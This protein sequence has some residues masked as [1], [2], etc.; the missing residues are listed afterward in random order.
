MTGTSNSADSEGEIR[1]NLNAMES[2]LVEE[3]IEFQI[4]A[5]SRHEDGKWVIGPIS[6][7]EKQELVERIGEREREFSHNLDHQAAEWCQSARSKV[8]RAEITRQSTSD[9]S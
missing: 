6:E 8:R 5:D 2:E 4:E 3:I 7:E 9:R 1:L